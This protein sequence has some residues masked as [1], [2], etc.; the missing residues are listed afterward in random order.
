MATAA[1][2]VRRGGGLTSQVLHRSQL[3]ANRTASGREGMSDTN[4]ATWACGRRDRNGVNERTLGESE[5]LHSLARCFS[6]RGV[7]L[8]LVWRRG[9]QLFGRVQRSDVARDEDRLAAQV[10]DGAHA[11]S[12]WVQTGGFPLKLLRRLQQVLILLAV[13]LHTGRVGVKRSTL[14]RSRGERYEIG[15]WI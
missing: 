15:L 6:D 1:G 3:W 11:Q 8:W 10:D 14:R 12:V 7:G 9:Q 4:L 2:G 13:K 5:R